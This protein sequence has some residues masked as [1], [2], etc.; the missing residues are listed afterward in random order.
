MT[1]SRYICV[2]AQKR[3]PLPL[4]CRHASATCRC[5]LNK[6]FLAMLQAPASRQTVED[7]KREI[8]GQGSWSTSAPKVRVD[9]TAFQ[10]TLPCP[11]PL[12]VQGAAVHTCFVASHAAALC[13]PYTL[14]L[15]KSG[16]ATVVAYICAYIDPPA[17]ATVV[18]TLQGVRVWADG[19][20]LPATVELRVPATFQHLQKLHW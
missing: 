14:S 8:L 7:L 20:I 3:C 5:Q 4:V 10:S 15:F 9:L 12:L 19:V 1:V 2:L 11:W 6:T 18:C 13:V 17:D 16:T